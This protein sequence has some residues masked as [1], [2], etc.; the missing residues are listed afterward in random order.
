MF[1]FFFQVW[2][3]H[4]NVQFPLLLFHSMC[5]FLTTLYL[6]YVQL[7]FQHLESTAE[8]DVCIENPLKSAKWPTKV[9]CNE[10]KT[11][12]KVLIF[13]SLSLDSTVVHFPMNLIQLIE[14]LQRMKI[15]LKACR[16]IHANYSKL[17][18]T[19]AQQKWCGVSLKS[20]WIVVG[21]KKMDIISDGCVVCTL[22][23]YCYILVYF[24]IVHWASKNENWFNENAMWIV[25]C[26]WYN[27]VGGGRKKRKSIKSA[28]FAFHF[29]KL[30]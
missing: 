12:A 10:I 19:H 2:I 13:F 7:F 15:R 1:V 29:N 20:S 27:P 4:W 16:F 28:L 21:E 3:F 5:F 26:S 22:L 25:V 8:Y 6:F 11:I 18:S 14:Q 23:L 30:S 9:D 24:E 17:S